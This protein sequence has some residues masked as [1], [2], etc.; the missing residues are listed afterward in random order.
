MEITQ[1]KTPR[2]A[3]SDTALPLPAPGKALAWHSS[4]RRGSSLPRASACWGGVTVPE[5]GH[6]CGYLGGLWVPLAALHIPSRWVP[7]GVAS[8]VKGA[9]GGSKSREW[10]C[11]GAELGVGLVV[12][13]RG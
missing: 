13:S 5:L 12:G 7:L 4:A 11:R 10:S 8:G 2:S 6:R 1:M 9:G 3:V